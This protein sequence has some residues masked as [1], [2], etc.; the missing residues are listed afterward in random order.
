MSSSNWKDNSS[1]T[2]LNSIPD[3]LQGS[4][5]GLGCTESSHVVSPVSQEGFEGQ[6]LLSLWTC[7]GDGGSWRRRRRASTSE[8]QSR[9]QNV[10]KGTFSVTSGLLE[11]CNQTCPQ[12]NSPS[13]LVK[14]LDRFLKAN[15]RS[16]L[17]NWKAT[18]ARAVRV[19][20]RQRATMMRR[21]LRSAATI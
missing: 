7:C 1:W 15:K 8:L 21:A 6:T 3:L 16:V 17:Q 5:P 4:H 2:G 20:E 14:R 9:Q 11:V 12:H 10:V 13:C 18:K 19:A